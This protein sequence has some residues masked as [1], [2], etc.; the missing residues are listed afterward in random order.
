MNDHTPFWFLSAVA[1]WVTSFFDRYGSLSLL[2][3]LA[4]ILDVL[5][6]ILKA[7]AAHAVN[8]NTGYQGFWK[9][10]SL[11]AGLFFGYFLDLFEAFLVSISDLVSVSFHI[12]FGTIIGIYIILNESISICEN[13]NAC[14]VR[15]PAFLAK[16]LLNAN[17]ELDG[18]QK[19]K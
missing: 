14:G 6:G 13:L 8:S 7:K 16:A 2:V 15:L 1:G 12:P 19:K 10:M 3:C 18:N 17:Q 11:F 4:V 9:K 5:T